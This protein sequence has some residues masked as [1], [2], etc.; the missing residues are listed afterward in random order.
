M[1]V[2]ES[3]FDTDFVAT[4]KAQKQV[5]IS[6]LIDKLSDEF[7]E[8]ENMNAALT[9]VDL[10]ETTEFCAM[11]ARKPN[12][13]KIC[14]LSFDSQS[15]QTRN[16]SKLV[17]EKLIQRIN[18]K[19]GNRANDNHGADEDDDIIIKQ[20][21]DDEEESIDATIDASVVEMLSCLIPKIK[22]VL[23]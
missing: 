15:Q 22:D 23:T 17:L 8:N 2:E 19:K 3:N 16:S 11:V 13:R 1:N 9:L 4:I 21:S 10:I 14:E 18:E 5:A 6:K 7:D 20:D 12:I